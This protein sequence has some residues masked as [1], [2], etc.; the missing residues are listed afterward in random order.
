M[1]KI[2]LLL[3]LAIISCSRD[4]ENNS[5][6]KYI[7]KIVYGTGENFSFSYENKKL[8]KI[9]AVYGNRF[10]EINITYKDNL[11]Y[12]IDL[13][14]LNVNYKA[15]LTYNSNNNLVKVVKNYESGNDFSYGQVISNIEYNTNNKIIRIITDYGNQDIDNVTFTYKNNV[16]NSVSTRSGERTISYDN[17]K[18]PYQNIDK[19]I[20]IAVFLLQ[21][22]IFPEYI[23]S[24]NNILQF[25]S[26]NYIFQSNKYTYNSDNLP[27]EKINEINS[28]VDK[29]EYLNY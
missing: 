16:V 22:E 20:I 7:S 26:K 3:I 2:L 4:N 14:S 9:Q 23:N 29:Y 27:I 19:G 28:S 11:P 18:N 6:E 10:S 1:K 5:N 13:T 12:S 8:K 17:K 21:G 24:E 25:N 15:I